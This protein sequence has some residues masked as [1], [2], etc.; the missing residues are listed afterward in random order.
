LSSRKNS[1][2]VVTPAHNEEDS[3]N[4]VADS[5]FAQTL[6]PTEWII[7]DDASTDGTLDVAKKLA[8]SRAWVKVV[9]HDHEEG[10]YDASFKAF[11]FGADQVGA[12]WHFL[13]K[14]D[15]DTRLPADH[16]ERLIAKFEA[17]RLLGIASGVNAGEPGIFSHPRGNNRMY[18]REC[19]GKISFPKDGWGWDSV[20]E[21]FARL[22]GWKTN[23]FTDIVCQHLRSRLPDA[24]YRF[25]QGR[26]SGHLGYYW[27]FVFGRSTKILFSSGPLASIAYLAGYL[28]GPLGPIDRRLE[29]AVRLDQRGR[30]LR[31]LGLSK[32]P[33]VPPSV[34]TPKADG[35][36]P[37]VAVGMPTLNRSKHLSQVLGALH[38]CEY[39]RKRMRLIF[40][41]GYST[42]GTFEM[43]QDF[44]GQHA[45]EYERIILIQER[46]NI[47][48]ARNLCI[49]NIGDAQFL[50]F[51]D[52][53]VLPTQ[54][55]I[56]RLIGLAQAG[57]IVTILYSSPD[58]SVPKG[59]IKYVHTVG[60]GCT[61]I[62]REVISRVGMFDSALPVGEDTDYC[63]RARKMGYTIIQDNTALLLH[64]DEGR[65]KL[66]RAVHPS[67]SLRYRRVYAKL[68]TLGVY[69]NRF[70]LY[71]LLDV[72]VILG[73]L[74][75]PLFFAGLLSYF[76]VQLI[77]HRS[78]KIAL[79][80]AANSL[81]LVP[82]AILG[83]VE[84]KIEVRS[85]R[86]T[87]STH[88]ST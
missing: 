45:Q 39:P 8:E 71:G 70:I 30:I 16:I 68:C 87:P 63:L 41:D 75:H 7:V 62:K 9:H 13:I 54:N 69:R 88:D 15:A 49:R 38:E 61:L 66:E 26:L 78:M 77:K 2:M 17:D 34:Y 5:V 19:W 73:L 76:T 43:L 86:D 48:A 46:T 14:L 52:S 6:L 80:I 55:V 36:D 58:R 67:K 10:S 28:R 53:D 40:V 72:T 56:D 83:L 85:A 20:D 33:L 57:E 4:I 37:L 25:H 11:K 22:N 59:Q 42:D 35:H 1:V 31:T 44:A 51:L 29:Q 64:L 12:D 21:I 84:T 79:Y 3:L 32:N 24:Y 65:Q 18:R 27:W 81:I 82:L 23:A 60:M 74:L 47:P 50:L